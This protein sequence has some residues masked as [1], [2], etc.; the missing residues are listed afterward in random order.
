M[1]WSRKPP[2]VRRLSTFIFSL[3][4][5]FLAKGEYVGGPRGTYH[6]G[7]CNIV[8][9]D[10]ITENE[11]NAKKMS[12]EAF[13]KQDVLNFLLGHNLQSIT[14]DDGAGKKA[15]IKRNSKG[16]YSVQITSNELL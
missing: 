15:A 11:A 1:I 4:R 10:V 6:E 2:L 8:A 7:R 13:V 9:Q 5:V 12:W 3:A 14:V 16:E